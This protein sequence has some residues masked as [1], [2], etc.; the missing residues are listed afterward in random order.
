MLDIATICQR[1]GI[2]QATF[3]RLAKNDAEFR[4]YL[5]PRKHKPKRGAVTYDDDVLDWLLANRA[6]QSDDAVASQEP[7]GAHETVAPVITP[8]D[9]E[10]AAEGVVERLA[11][12]LPNDDTAPAAD[13]GEDGQTEHASVRPQEPA[14]EPERIDPVITPD[15]EKKRLQAEI[16]SLR[17]RL[18]KKESDCDELMRQNG[19]I[20]MLFGAEKAEKQ[21]LLTDGR[22]VE[23]DTDRRRGL[24]ERLRILFRGK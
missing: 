17:A 5:E 3:Y 10:S 19:Q 21:Q 1:T 11:D 7:A 22:R 12:G 18:A 23:Q 15:D 2:S 16:E 4:A 8:P 20:L 24:G 9:V 14:R 6:A 13:S